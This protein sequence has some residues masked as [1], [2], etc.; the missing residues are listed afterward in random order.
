MKNFFKN[1][2]FILAML[3]GIVAGCVVGLVA[4]EFA[5]NLEP[6]APCSPT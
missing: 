3:T 4:P 5:G 2:G 6:L 1:Y